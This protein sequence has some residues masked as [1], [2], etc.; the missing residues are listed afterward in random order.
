MMKYTCAENI[1]S[2]EMKIN[3]QE[4]FFSFFYLLTLKLINEDRMQEMMGEKYSVHLAHIFLISPII[5]FQELNHLDATILY[6]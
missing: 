6:T 1:F 3:R 2:V 4:S 5:T